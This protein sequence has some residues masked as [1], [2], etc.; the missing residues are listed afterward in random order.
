M[1][2][3]LY[4]IPVTFQYCMIEIL[5]DLIENIMEVLMDDFSVY[6]ASYDLCL[7]NLTKVL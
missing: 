4:N 7:T 6:R 3:V 5:F 2:F 1:P